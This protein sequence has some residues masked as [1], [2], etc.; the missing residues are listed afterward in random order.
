LTSDVIAAGVI[1]WAVAAI[2][3]LTQRGLIVARILLFAGCIALI[4]AA[5]AVN[6]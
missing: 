3:S 1:A 5:I 4:A 6:R 2:T